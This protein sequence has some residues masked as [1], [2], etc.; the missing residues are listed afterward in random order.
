MLGTACGLPMPIDTF[1]APQPVSEQQFQ[2]VV[3]WIAAGAPNN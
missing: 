3:D 2:M 1:G